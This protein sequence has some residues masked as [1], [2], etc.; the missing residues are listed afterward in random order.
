MAA[1]SGLPLGAAAATANGFE[2]GALAVGS[3]APNAWGLYDMPPGPGSPQPRA[4]YHIG[5]RVALSLGK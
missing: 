5:F 4:R 3:L 1:D 2:P